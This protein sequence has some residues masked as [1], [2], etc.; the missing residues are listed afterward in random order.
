MACRALRVKARREAGHDPA[1][2]MAGLD[3]GGGSAGVWGNGVAA[4]RAGGVQP[5]DGRRAAVWAGP[6]GAVVPGLATAPSTTRRFERLLANER[7]DVRRARG[8]IGAAVL[9]QARGQ[10]V[11]LALDETPQGHTVD[12]PRLVMLALRLV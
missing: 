10:T 2:S 4:A 5:G 3:G 1:G 6:G 12:G 9:E 11:W 7:L 8:A